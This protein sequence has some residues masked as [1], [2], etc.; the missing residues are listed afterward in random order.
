M[1]LVDMLEKPER[2]LRAV[3]TFEVEHP[4]FDEFKA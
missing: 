3:T 4:F 1:R 2:G